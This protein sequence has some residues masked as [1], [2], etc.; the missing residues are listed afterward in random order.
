M[1]AQAIARV[2][3]LTGAVAQQAQRVVQGKSSSAGASRTDIADAPSV[4]AGGLVKIL[5]R[6]LSLLVSVLGGILAGAVFK[7]GGGGGLR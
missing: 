4:S 3:Q 7:K 5:Y 6:P 2:P 1:R